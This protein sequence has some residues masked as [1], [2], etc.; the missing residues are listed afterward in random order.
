MDGPVTQRWI[1]AHA[2]RWLSRQGYGTTHLTALLKEQNASAYIVQLLTLLFQCLLCLVDHGEVQSLQRGHCRSTVRL[3]SSLATSDSSS[4]LLAAIMTGGANTEGQWH[5]HKNGE[6]PSDPRK[7]EQRDTFSELV[8]LFLEHISH[9]IS[10]AHY[11]PHLI[12]NRLVVPFSTQ[13]HCG[14]HFDDDKHV[15]R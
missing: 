12:L 8:S 3:A 15:V 4:L 11:C 5:L 6:C 13:H 10:F 7:L 2:T 9:I 1:S 14:P